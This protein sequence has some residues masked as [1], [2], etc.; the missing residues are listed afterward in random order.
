MERSGMEDRPFPSFGRAGVLK[1]PQ[2]DY[3]GP[4]GFNCLAGRLHGAFRQGLGA[5]LGREV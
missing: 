5:N 2:I 3:F 1:I 4:L